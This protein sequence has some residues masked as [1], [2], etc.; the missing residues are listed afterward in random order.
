MTTFEKLESDMRNGCTQDVLGCDISNA[1]LDANTTNKEIQQI[2]SSYGT[3]RLIDFSLLCQC[4][5]TYAEQKRISNLLKELSI[6]AH[7]L[8]NKI[9]ADIRQYIFDLLIS[10]NGYKRILGRRLWDD[11]A[12]SMFDYDL[13]SYP[14]ETQIRFVISILQDI[15]SPKKRLPRAF[16]MFNSTSKDVRNILK[17]ACVLYVLNYYGISRDIFFSQNYIPSE[18]VQ[19]FEI[20]IKELETWFDVRRNCKEIDSNYLYPTL[21]DLSKRAVAQYFKEQFESI[22][23]NSAPSF[24]NLVSNV[25]LGRGGGMRGQDGNI[26]PL[27]EF[28]CSVEIPMMLLSLTPLE[29]QNL[30]TYILADWS[31][32]NFNDEK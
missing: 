19:L 21:Y 13:L 24:L 4:V 17:D 8:T 31:K 9:E 20:F 29:E 12:H 23:Q 27:S 5:D 6:C 2:F 30:N 22:E 10:D 32:I 7:F 15:Q 26:Q 25:Q 28:S 1:L 3:R 11:F 18:E 14:T 16:S